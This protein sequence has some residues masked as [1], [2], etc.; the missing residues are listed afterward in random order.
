MSILVLS[1]IQWR[2]ISTKYDVNF[3]KIVE[4]FI[5][6]NHNIKNSYRNKSKIIYLDNKSYYHDTQDHIN[7]MKLEYDKEKII[8]LSF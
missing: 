5:N 8:N 1:K 6:N 2:L 4:T 3:E 7:P